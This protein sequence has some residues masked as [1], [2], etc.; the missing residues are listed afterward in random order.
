MTWDHTMLMALATWPACGLIFWASL[1]RLNC[2]RPDVLLR[3]VLEHA[4]YLAIATAVFLGPTVG[5]WPGPIML[6]V[7]WAVAI[8]MLCEWHAWKD[9]NGKD[10]E[11]PPEASGYMH[12]FPHESE[13]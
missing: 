8:I 12:L 7:I 10:D 4:L 3:V 2:M 1:C 11:Q 9:A 13:P 6:G 5:E